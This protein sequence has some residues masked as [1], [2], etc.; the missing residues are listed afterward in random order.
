[1]SNINEIGTTSILSNWITQFRYD[2]IPTDI[3]RQAKAC[4]L[5]SVACVV[6]GINSHPSAIIRDVLV[7]GHGS[8]GAVSLPGTDI[9]MGVLGASYL[10]A[11]AANFLDFD[12]SFRSGAASHPGATVVPPALAVAEERG[13]SGAEFLTAVVAGYEISL[14]I[15][16]AI[17]ASPSRKKMV[18]GFSPWQTFGATTAAAHL[19]KLDHRRI[20]HAFGLSGSQ[21][22]VPSIRKFL[23]G[24]PPFSWAK[25]CYGIASE[26]GV[27]SAMLA[28]RNFL[29]SRE[30]FDGESGFWVMSGSDS[31]LKE[32]AVAD[33]GSKWLILDVGFKPYAC[34]RWTHTLLDS[35]RVLM[36]RLKNE[37]VS[38]I[39][40]YGFRE[41]THTLNKPLPTSI[42]DAQFNARYLA[43]LELSGHSPE[44]GL[45]Q[46][47]LT[48]K[49]IIELAENTFLHH[50]P[51][52]DGEFFAKGALP[53]RVVVSCESGA[54]FSADAKWPAGSVEAG[55][56]KDTTMSSKFLSVT[57]PVIG[58]DKASEALAI[59]NQLEKHD[60]RD[61]TRCLSLATTG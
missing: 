5:D 35:L 55:G 7:Q 12:D 43:A 20:V 27:L 6:G 25:N 48:D 58:N 33:L 52:A 39:D 45:F 10:G 46:E 42:I 15:G 13:R 60:I 26:V 29:G 23:E 41:L 1:M 61:L 38:K 51:V 44:A 32:L 9:R 19:M 4:C 24:E 8:G 36:P 34:C 30:I 56:F 37:I 59:I 47:D 22:P 31:Y 53:V 49:R 3:L 17:Q 54:T 50:D 14:R 21:A 40:V 57:S 2:D 28:E 16:R 18:M 11:Q